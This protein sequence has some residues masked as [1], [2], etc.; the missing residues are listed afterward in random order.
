MAI[1][2]RTK[3]DEKEEARK[4]NLQPAQDNII[5]KFFLENC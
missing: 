4:E 2:T 5:I 3:N 1:K